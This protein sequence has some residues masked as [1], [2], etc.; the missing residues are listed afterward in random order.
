MGEE[1][2][3]KLTDTARERDAAIDALNQKIAALEAENAQLRAD[4]DCVTA[5][6]TDAK[7]FSDTLKAKA[8]A[9]DRELRRRNAEY[10]EEQRRRI[11]DFR[12]EID[13]VRGSVRRLLDVIERDFAESAAALDAVSAKLGAQK[14]QADGEQNH[15]E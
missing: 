15:E 5:V 3:R 10:N 4:R 13:E 11:D 7:R 2:S 1:F 8:E 14:N 6:M 12:F 9:E